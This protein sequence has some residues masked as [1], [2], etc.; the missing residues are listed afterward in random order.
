MRSRLRTTSQRVARRVLAATG[1]DAPSARNG[2]RASRAPKTIAEGWDAYAKRRRTQSRIGDVWNNPKIMGLDIDA[3]ADVVGHLDR[4]VFAPF[5]GEPDVMVEIGPGG[6]R[7]TEALLPRC[8]VLHAVDTS[9]NMIES[10]RERFGED[11][12]VVYHVADGSGLGMLPDGSANA[13]FS[14]GVFV[15]LQHWDIF[16]YL[17]EIERVLRPGGKAIVQHSNTFSELGWKRFRSDVPRQL[18]RHK[19]PET[20]VLN[21]PELMSELI[22]RAGLE[23]VDMVTNV[24]KR[25]CIALI[26]KPD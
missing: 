2:R 10:L 25:D 13:A 8:R 21:S 9:P 16:N 23:P 15:H 22:R 3:Q 26:R 4:E 5:L 1:G 14:Y 11:S 24:A 7:F 18:N 17:S 20:F 12:G 6:G 19:L